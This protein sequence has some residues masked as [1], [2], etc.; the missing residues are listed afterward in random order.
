MAAEKNTLIK[1]LAEGSKKPADLSEEE[2]NL[3]G[4]D[5][6]VLERSGTLQGPEGLRREDAWHALQN[7]ITAQP[8]AKQAFISSPAR[9]MIAALLILG[10]GLGLFYFLRPVSYRSPLGESRD[11]TLPDGSLAV[12][13]PGSV[14]SSPWFASSKRQY[15]LQGEAWFSVKKGDDDFVLSTGEFDV[16]VLGTRFN[17][18]ARR[19]TAGVACA[20]G[21]VAVYAGE[22][23][24]VLVEGEALSS[25]AGILSQ[26]QR[27]S[28]GTVGSWRRGVFSF[29]NATPEVVF[30][31]LELYY[32]VSIRMEGSTS[33]RFTGSFTRAPLAEVL[34]VVC[35]PLGL[36]YTIDENQVLISN[37]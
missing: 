2:R 35:L 36:T 33:Q 8:E 23:V 31:E 1:A 14:L 22:Q 17:V 24:E 32:Q 15:Y 12:L 10:F 28:P 4:D 5:L 26:P 20:E 9:A 25:V 29:K 27:V 21:K 11:I 3:L 13:S 16:K 7:K 6:A 34:D 37:Q 18:N 19:G 30:R